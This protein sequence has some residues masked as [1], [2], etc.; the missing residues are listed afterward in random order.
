MRTLW[1]MRYCRKV[2]GDL[3]APGLFVDLPWS[4]F[5]SCALS[6]PPILAVLTSVQ[7]RMIL[8][9]R[10]CDL[11]RF[12]ELTVYGRCNQAQWMKGGEDQYSYLRVV[13]N[14]GKD[15]DRLLK[16]LT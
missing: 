9:A 15:S 12:E 3:A 13:I 2:R 16:G 4:T 8:V 14:I 6:P 10:K 5:R 11:T 1:N 7:S